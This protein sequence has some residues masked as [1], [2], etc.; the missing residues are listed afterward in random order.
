MD[1]DNVGGVGRVV[2]V[3]RVVFLCLFF[4]YCL[5]SSL[6]YFFFGCFM[7]FLL[8]CIVF[9]LVIINFGLNLIGIKGGCRGD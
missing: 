1:V 3:R 9:F 4:S 5:V 7:L 8:F 2:R 6:V